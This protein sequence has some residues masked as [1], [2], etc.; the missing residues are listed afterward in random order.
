MAFVVMT[1]VLVAFV[2][3]KFVYTTPIYVTFVFQ[4][5]NIK[6]KFAYCKFATAERTKS[7]FKLIYTGK[8][9]PD[10]SSNTSQTT[11]NDI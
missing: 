2:P 10:I 4:M 7:I 1:F 11:Q 8:S 5:W 6:I 9:Q 3:F